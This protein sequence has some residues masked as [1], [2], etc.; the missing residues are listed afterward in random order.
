MH[1]KIKII[2]WNLK[3]TINYYFWTQLSQ[4]T[5]KKTH[6]STCKRTNLSECAEHSHRPII[7]IVSLCSRTLGSRKSCRRLFTLAQ[8]IDTD[9]LS[10]PS[11][12]DCVCQMCL[13]HYSSHSL[14][15]PLLMLFPPLKLSKRMLSR[16]GECNC[17][18]SNIEKRL[19]L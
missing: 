19:L 14:R 4:V 17:L 16:S 1:R 7:I 18:W 10:L 5:L 11:R 3:F 13:S 15:S 2:C 12:L 6:D 8:L 9:R